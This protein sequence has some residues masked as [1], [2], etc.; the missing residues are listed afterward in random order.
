MANDVGNLVATGTDIAFGDA[1]W[2]GSK[3]E[4][5]Q[6]NHIMQYVAERGREQQEY[7]DYLH[8]LPIFCYLHFLMDGFVDWAGRVDERDQH[9]RRWWAGKVMTQARIALLTPFSP[10]GWISQV[11]L[12]QS[13]RQIPEDVRLRWDN[14][15]QRKV[16][17]AYN[18]QRYQEREA[19]IAQQA[20]EE[21]E[22]NNHSTAWIIW[23]EVGTFAEG[24]VSL[25]VDLVEG[26]PEVLKERANEVADGMAGLVGMAVHPVQTYHQ[27][28]ESSSGQ[29]TRMM[30]ELVLGFLPLKT[31][32]PKLP[33]DMPRPNPGMEVVGAD[34]MV[35]RIA[36]KDLPGP[37]KNGYIRS[38]G[39]DKPQNLGNIVKDGGKTTYKNPAGNELTWVDQH[40]KNINRDIDSFLNSS[41]VGKATEAKVA[42]FLRQQKEVTGFGQKVLKKDGQAAGDLDVVTKDEMIEV[43]ASLKAVKEG[44]LEKMT[45]ATDE[46]YF[47]PEQKKVILYID[48]PFGNLSPRDIQKLEQIKELGVTIVNSL[49]ELGKVIK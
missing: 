24:G 43:K 12:E 30:T 17:E 9:Y 46:F 11:S 31:K 42:D 27:I 3:E 16:W 49:D 38:E 8:D 13:Y 10:I 44:Q 22:R 29:K 15:T 40:P 45:D 35:Y 5:Y 1:T 7:I 25:F 19:E 37:E 18:L 28:S 21:A 34:G 2:K 47:N 20:A 6:R 41:D 4:L 48:K 14:E 33:F 36:E 23:D 26:K 39:T 32:V